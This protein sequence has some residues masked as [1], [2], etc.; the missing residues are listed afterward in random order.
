MKRSGARG[1]TITRAAAAGT[2]LG[3]LVVPNI[4][5]AIVRSGA[6]RHLRPPEHVTSETRAELKARMGRHGET[7]SELV[8]A[9]VLLDRPT[10]RVLASQV[11]DEEVIA[12]GRR[13]VHEQ[14]PLSLPPEFFLQQTKLVVA[15]RDLAA[16]AVDGSEDKALADR[17][18]IVTGTC[19]ACH[20]A[21]LHGQP[22]GGPWGVKQNAKGGTP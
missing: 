7:M 18:A 9:V 17:F 1:R 6:A 15:A 10:V 20:S 8:R 5:I 22:D 14:P 21:Y 3:F 4:G 13:S 19:L 2:L 11:A 12:R 16:A